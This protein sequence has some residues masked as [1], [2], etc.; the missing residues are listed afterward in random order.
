MDSYFHSAI[1]RRYY[2]DVALLRRDHRASDYVAST[3]SAGLNRGQQDV[4]STNSNTQRRAHVRSYHWRFQFHVAASDAA[5]H[6]AAVFVCR[7]HGRIKN[8]FEAG[9]QGDG[10]LTWS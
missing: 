4:P 10:F 6:G 3:Q 1:H 5:S 9:Q 8:V 2:Y 7:D